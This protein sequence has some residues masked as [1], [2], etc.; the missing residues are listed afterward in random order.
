M[1]IKILQVFYDK[2]G[3]P[4]KDKERTVHYPITSGTFLGASNTTQIRFY[5]DQLDELNEST[6][7]AV[8]KLPNG[9]IGSE[10]LESEYDSELQENYAVL[11]LSKFYTQYKGD[12]YISL[13]GYEGGVRVEQD[14]NGI[15]SILGT[16]TIQATGSIRM[17]VAYAPTFIGSGQTENVTLQ[18]VLAELSTKLGIR[19]ETLHVEELPTVGNPNIFYVVNDDPDN[20][21]KEN[22]YIWNATTKHYIWVGDNTLDLSN[23]YTKEEGE[24]FEEE[25]DNRVSNVEN[26]LSN[27]ASGSPKGVY[28]TLA[29]LQTAYPTGTSGIFVVSADGHWY[30]WNGS[31]WTDGGVYQATEIAN[32]SVKYNKLGDDVARLFYDIKNV[33]GDEDGELEPSSIVLQD[34]YVDYSTGNVSN[35]GGTETAVYKRTDYLP[36]PI[37]TY[38][39]SV[40]G[41]YV[42]CLYDKDKNPITTT[43]IG[44]LGGEMSVPSNAVY[45]VSSYLNFT[46]TPEIKYFVN[47]AWK[48]NNDLVKKVNEQLNNLYGFSP[49]IKKITPELIDGYVD[50]RNGNITTWSDDGQ[51]K[52]TDYIALPQNIKKIESNL[53][54]NAYA[55]YCFFDKDKTFISGGTTSNIIEIPANAYYVMLSDY[56]SNALHTNRFILLF[57]G[58][59]PSICCYGDSVTAG[60]GVSDEGSSSYKGKNYPAQ[61]KTLLI[62][63]GYVLDIVNNGHGGERSNEICARLGGNVCGYLGE[64]ITIP[65]N[66][67]MVSLG[68]AVVTNYQV[69]GSKINGTGKNYDGTQAEL[70]FTATNRHTRPMLVGDRLCNFYQAAGSSG[71]IQY[72]QL[73]T[74]VGKEIVIPKYS[75]LAIGEDVPKFN[76]INVVFMGINDGG[77]M[78]L[79]M[80][81]NRNKSFI[82][83][84][85][86]TIVCGLFSQ[87]WTWWQ[88][89]VGTNEQKRAVYIEK[90][91][92]T[93]GSHFLDLYQIFTTE[94]CIEIANEGGYLLDRTQEQ[95]D[96]DNTAFANHHTCPSLTA[97]GTE[98]EVHFN[99]IG[100]YVF[101]RVV[102]DKLVALDM[103][104]K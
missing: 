52:R 47:K 12:V 102:Y 61:L 9:K 81:I 53:V 46:G 21:N 84:N 11:N 97:G 35:W 51:Y 26:E 15:Y 41:N 1:E 42:S 76:C 98:N 101:A 22:I 63:N 93:F 85:P 7:V 5:Y 82:D 103:V 37:G 44:N 39:L 78:S 74:S 92:E 30:Y 87:A 27:V 29:A 90:A 67:P 24:S 73:V 100:Y 64:D 99:E 36:I 88:G 34:G 4:Y 70:L 18:R 94:R 38:K 17:Y 16:P 13:Q 49:L 19:Q 14:E 6:F 8:S 79:D 58:D 25:I 96:A 56:D 62:D 54:T 59:M 60:Y 72:I 80:W 20:P 48:V 91:L 10:I 66:N 65:A 55:G 71:T 33:F 89:M 104:G 77:N 75:V 86:N 23:Y 2:N 57:G 3:L 45:V 32:G 31:A 83:T 50:Y 69:S 68:E 95:I 40:N 43:I 28:A